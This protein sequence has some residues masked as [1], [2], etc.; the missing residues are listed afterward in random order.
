MARTETTA[1]EL[2]EIA[3]KFSDWSAAILSIVDLMEEVH[4][5]CVELHSQTFLGLHVPAIEKFVGQATLDAKVQQ[6]HFIRGTETRSATQ[7]RYNQKRK[8]KDA[9]E[10]PA[11]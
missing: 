7:R 3:T 9:K 6:A 8:L 2:R 11:S 1:D 4:M 5:P 10:K